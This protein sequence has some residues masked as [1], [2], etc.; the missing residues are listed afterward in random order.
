MAG[1]LIDGGWLIQHRLQRGYS[2]ATASA[3]PSACIARALGGVAVS[4]VVVVIVFVAVFVFVVVILLEIA[5]VAPPASPPRS[6]SRPRSSPG[7]GRDSKRTRTWPGVEP[8]PSVIQPDVILIIYNNIL[9]EC[10]KKS[11]M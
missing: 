6:P 9:I 10:K 2:A 8:P 7:R 1:W 5:A 11:S 4:V 3:R